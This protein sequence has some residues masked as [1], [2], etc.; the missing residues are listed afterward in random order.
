MNLKKSIKIIILTL[1]ICTCLY[2]TQAQDL[3]SSEQIGSISEEELEATY[4]VGFSNGVDL[5]RVLYTTPD[6]L[7]VLDTA[8]GLLV[9]P[10]NPGFVYPLLAFQHGTVNSR[11]D[12][13]SQ[14]AGGYQLATVFGGQGY[15]TIAPDFVG[16]GEARGLHP[17]VH[18]D[19]E[20]SAAIDFLYAARQFA[21]QNDFLQL[22]DQVFVTGYS[23]GGH[24]ALA[25]HRA[26][27]LEYSD[28]F[29]VTA[30]APMS[31]PYSV[32]QKM[33]DFTL[34]DTPYSFVAY[35][36]WVAL[37]Y[38]LAYDVVDSLDEFF[39]PNYVPFIEQ[40]RDEEITLGQLN[41]ALT[42]ELINDVG[43]VTPKDMLQTNM[44]D[45]ILNDPTHPVSMALADNDLH[46]WEPQAPTRLVYCTADDQVYF[47]NATFADSIMNANGAVDLSSD[48]VNPAADHGGCVQPAMLYTI[49]FFNSLKEE[50]VATQELTGSL[51][52]PFLV[53]PNP[54]Q[55]ELLIQSAKEIGFANQVALYDVNGKQVKQ[56]KWSNT[57]LLRINVEDLNTGLYFLMIDSENG[58]YSMKVLVEKGN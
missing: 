11:W 16:L 46:N 12:V 32:S 40:F 2:Q 55:D 13:P 47:Q 8:S 23:Q 18:A 54:V 30:S 6:V 35:I 57:N 10:D 50:I 34:S 29:T 1:L 4:L 15:A 14:L 26:M 44:L 31:G 22:N 49:I 51:D 52:D 56:I 36:A 3:I 53:A 28:D 48:D 38:D 19:T 42:N 20:A 5:Y 24:A 37:S 33:I 41:A 7:G 27:E 58:R 45:V 21:D 17:Y 25:A 9:V 43:A 39:K